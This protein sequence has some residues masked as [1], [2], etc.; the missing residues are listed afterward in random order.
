MIAEFT[1]RV[2]LHVET[3][4]YTAISIKDHWSVRGTFASR[5]YPT[6]PKKYAMS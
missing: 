4:E 3:P 2:S 6:V 5:L 1:F